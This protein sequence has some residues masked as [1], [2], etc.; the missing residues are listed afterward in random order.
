[1][2]FIKTADLKTG[3][4]LARPIYNKKGV[5]LFERDS[6]L[7]A[8]AIDSVRNFGLLGVYILDPAEPVPPMTPDDVEFERFQTMAI[9]SIQDE[10]ERILATG[11][12]NRMQTVV[13]MIIKRYGHL[14]SRIN[15]YQSLR[16]R[17]DYVYKH[18]LNVAILCAMIT[19]VMNLSLQE[20]VQTVTAAIIHDV[21]K[22]S[23]AKELTAGDEHDEGRQ[24]LLAAAQIKA[25]ELIE[26][27]FTDGVSIRRICLQALRLQIDEGR[28]SGGKVVNGAKIL[29]VANKY[30]ELTSMKL[31]GGTDSEVKAIQ[32]FREQPEIYDPAV[33]KALTDSVNILFPG[34]SVEL[35]TGEKALVLVENSV[36]VLRPMVLSFRDNSVIDLSLSCNRDIRVVDIL[37]TLD[38]RYVMDT[39]TLKRVG[40]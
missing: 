22:A 21:G 14:E 1:M 16:S 15:F 26:Q 10:L 23:L 28:S 6:R 35:S 25:A 37:K 34:V 20:Q 2:Q 39:D 18:S 32:M 5:L 12:Q 3:M 11:K 33:V 4:R 24:K 31:G 13:S 30:D 19:H 7:T 17:E 40:F 9:F 8:P 38:N 36:D 29:M 27:V